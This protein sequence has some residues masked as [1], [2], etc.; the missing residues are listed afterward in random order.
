MYKTFDHNNKNDTTKEPMF[1]GA[2]PNIARYD[3]QKYPVFEKLI[4][5]HLG[6]FWRP[7]EINLMKDAKDFK[8]LSDHEKH[9]FLSNLKYQ[10]LLDSIQGR[11]PNVALLPVVSLPEL[12]TLIETWSFSETIH[13]RSYTYIIRNIV[14]NSDEVFRS[15]LENDSIINRAKSVSKYYDEFIEYSQWYSLLGY[16]THIVNGNKVEILEKVLKTKFIRMIYSI[17]ILEGIRFY[18]SFACSWAFAELKKMEGN[19]K[20][21]SFICRDE[22]IHLGITQNIIKYLKTGDDPYMAELINDMED[23]IIQ[24]YQDAVEQEKAWA[25]YLFKDGS[26]IGLNEKILNSYVEF[27]ANKRMRSIGLTQIF[28]QPSNPLP[29]TDNWIRS[30]GKQVAPQETEIESYV[31]GAIDNDLDKLSKGLNNFVL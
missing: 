3:I 30:K 23:E 14:N 27:I 5:K 8:E 24:M 19:A 7:E 10:T 12:E 29:W 25:E 15:I 2:T 20:I 16:G 17:N 28:N 1:F 31:I 13:S 26:I 6:F 21:I 9:I 11:S 18:V 4:T 22:N